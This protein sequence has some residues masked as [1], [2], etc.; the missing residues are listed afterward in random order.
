M[1]KDY[2]INNIDHYLEKYEYS[3]YVDIKGKT[4]ENVWFNLAHGGPIINRR[5]PGQKDTFII[6]KNAQTRFFHNCT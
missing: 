5:Y 6:P 3:K 1:G 2:S 4:F